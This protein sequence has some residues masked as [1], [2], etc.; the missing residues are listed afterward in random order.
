MDIWYEFREDERFEDGIA[1]AEV[2]E[3]LFPF[4]KTA[5]GSSERT[6]QMDGEKKDCLR[7]DQ[8]ASGTRE[9]FGYRLV[10]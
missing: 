10:V 5:R 1:S 3:I 8:R 7:P 9:I 2:N 6:G 4:R